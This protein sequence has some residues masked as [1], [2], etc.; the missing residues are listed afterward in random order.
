M[1]SIAMY[2]MFH[3]LDEFIGET[4]EQH[5]GPFLI[6]GPVFQPVLLGTGVLATLWLILL[7][8]YHRKIYLRI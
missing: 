1:N 5:L 3:T 6:L 7:W 8:M 4:L 2:V